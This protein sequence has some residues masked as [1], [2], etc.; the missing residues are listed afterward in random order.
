MITITGL[1]DFPTAG[2]AVELAD[3]RTA[4]ALTHFPTP[5]TSEIAYSAAYVVTMT[6]A[7]TANAVKIG[8]SEPFGKDIACWL[9]MKGTVLRLWA[10][11][12]PPGGGGAQ[13]RLDLYEWNIGVGAAGGGGSGIDQQ[14]RNALAALPK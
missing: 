1:D 9:T 14:L 11:E 8:Q 7:T 13:A 5:G 2:D 10:T 4:L 3:G 12:P 6:S